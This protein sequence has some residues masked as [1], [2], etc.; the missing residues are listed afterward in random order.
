MDAKDVL[1]QLVASGVKCAIVK[2]EY[3]KRG[4]YPAYES[5]LALVGTN[6]DSVYET[7]II[8]KEVFGKAENEGGNVTALVTLKE[9][10]EFEIYQQYVAD[11]VQEIAL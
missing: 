10:E 9:G 6:E 2:L 1:Q 5:L 3:A 4:K 7:F 11:E 8:N